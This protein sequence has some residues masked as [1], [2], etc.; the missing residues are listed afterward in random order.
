M[1]VLVC[2]D[3][4]SRG[5][6]L[7]ATIKETGQEMDISPCL[8]K[9][10][11][12]ALEG[13]FERVES[14]LKDPKKCKT[15][16]K[17]A[18][19]D[20]DVVIL[21][22]NLA[23]LHIKGTRLTA[24]SLAG[25]VR[26][27]TGASY[28]VSLNKNP[29]VDFDLRY[30]VG[31]Y[32]T[33]ADLAL[34]ATHLSNRA[35]WTGNT[36]DATN[37]FL[38]WY[39]PCLNTV[40]GR[41]REQIAFVQ[42]HLHEPVFSSLDIPKAAYNFLSLHARGALYPLAEADGARNDGSK[43]LEEVT[44]M[45]VFLARDRSLPV[46][47]DRKSLYDFAGDEI[48]TIV[49]R[50]VAS[51]VDLW[52]RRDVLGPQE[53]L[54]D[55]PHLLARMPFLLGRRASDIREWQKTVLTNTPPFGLDPELYKKHVAKTKFEHDMWVRSP[56]LWWAE[57]KGDENLDALFFERKQ[58]EWPDAVFCEDKSSFV[59]RLPE[60]GSPPTEFSAE[61]EGSWGRRYVAKVEHTR[62]VP[63]SRFAVL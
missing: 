54:V 11:T 26:A 55:V 36:E 8:D 61:F 15:G 16:K 49:S 56:A 47:D 2:D 27:F 31:D 46:E 22:N 34:N 32:A 48:S 43:P 12:G 44:F 20:I 6:E 45:D 37:G 10:L 13:L 39:W 60:N 5:K 59:E 58:E 14:C 17:L 3:Q 4:E 19:D 35:L 57:L 7:I 53:A 1:R 21:D 40:A 42:S 38:P 33:H 41:R 63:L 25:Y 51:D 50:A 18:F 52:F 29:N 24:E 30:L 62:Y 23:N 9:D 28:V